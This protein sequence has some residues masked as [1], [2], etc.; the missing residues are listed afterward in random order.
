MSE[1][2]I[3]TRMKELY[4]SHPY[5]GC[6]VV[7]LPHEVL[8]LAR[9]LDEAILS[10][11]SVR[12][13]ERR[14]LT[15][16]QIATLFY[17]AYGETRKNDKDTFPRP[18]R[19]VPSGGGLYPLEVFFHT[20]SFEGHQAGVYHYNPSLHNLRLLQHG[21]LTDKISRV[22]VHQDI[23][24]RTSLVIFITALFERSI[25][26]YGDRGYRFVLLEAGH[27]AQNINLVAGALGLASVN[28]GGF[29]DREVDDL[30]GLDGVTHSA[31]YM[32]MVGNP[33]T[34]HNADQ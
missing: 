29:F 20:T 31:I 13:M 30:L 25:F 9:P 5:W 33:T 27:V 22:M 1:N 12:E 32:I 18:F 26:K 15:L 21:D 23:A 17:Y 28:I 8:P 19:V 2:E 6:P 34:Q 3:L 16:Q 4:T 10:R 11:I 7:D 14:P 24:P